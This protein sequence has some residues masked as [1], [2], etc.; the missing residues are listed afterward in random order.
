[1]PLDVACILGCAVITGVG[2]VTRVAQVRRGDSVGV[3]GCGPIGLNVIQGARHAGAEIIVGADPKPERRELA[4]SFGATHAI[5]PLA[6]DVASM[7]R[8]LTG[9]RGADHGFETAGREDALQTTLELTRP[10]GSVT[11]LGKMDPERHVRLRFGSLMG[12]RTIRRSAL[13]GGQAAKDIP[14]FVKAYL[15]GQL[16]LDELVTSRVPLASINPALADAGQ[17]T[18]IRSVLMLS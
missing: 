18:S 1:M 5:D 17:G 4:L 12:D 7:M 15:E 11:V 16:M 13:G 9:G 6:D 8:S 10:G 2:A 3:T 14:A